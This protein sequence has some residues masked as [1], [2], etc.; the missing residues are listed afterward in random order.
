VERE[1]KLYANLAGVEVGEGFPVRIVGAINV[2]PESFYGG[3]VARGR[4][5]LQ[6]L[7][8][9]LI[10]EGADIIDIGA[11]S[12]APYRNGAISEDDERHR[13]QSAVRAVRA[14]AD[15]PIS[16]DTQRSRVAA[17]ALQA[18]AAIINDVSGLRDDP[19]MG[20]VARDAAGVILMANETGLR[21]VGAARPLLVGS[22][23]AASARRDAS[24]A[25]SRSQARR[26]VGPRTRA[27]MAMISSL[28]RQ[29]LTRARA[30]R[31]AT[32]RIVLD[33]GIGFFRRA[34]VPSYELDCLVL[35][36]LGQLRRLGHP[37]LV[38][39][40]RKSFIGKLTGRDNPAE[41]L[42]GSLGATAVA[43]YNGA[44]L[45]RTH[46]V[47]ATRDAVRVVERVR[48]E[49]WVVSFEG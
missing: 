4:G 40:S 36:E 49:G 32:S 48:N 35:R 34:A 38:G 33:P 41:R 9:R 26:G 27:P 11:M 16:A 39:V 28:L 24:A 17:A 3:A 31:V 44:A 37:L 23:S 10:D 8:A 25:P 13:M 15:V 21:A 12:T 22:R 46:D 1:V 30:A 20:A 5:A 47:A 19:A 2:S 42:F 43:V 29:C 45:I 14:V 7:V 18:G 6:K